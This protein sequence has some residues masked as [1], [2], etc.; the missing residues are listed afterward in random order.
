[1][2]GQIARTS[3]ARR[4]TSTVGWGSLSSRLPSLR[5]RIAR[6]NL[7]AALCVLFAPCVCLCV[8][9]CPI[10]KSNRKTTREPTNVFFIQL[11]SP[12]S[13]LLFS[14]LLACCV[15]VFCFVVLL[16]LILLIS[17]RRWW[18]RKQFVRREATLMDSTRKDLWL[19]L[20]RRILYGCVRVCVRA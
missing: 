19:G 4:P 10:E 7:P 20:G 6:C 16:C 5:P 3:P 8:C 14:S 13:S 17:Q 18:V 15:F 1:M 9:V 2:V 12:F 11:V